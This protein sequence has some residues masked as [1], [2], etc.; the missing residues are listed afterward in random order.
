VRGFGF[1]CYPNHTAH[2]C[3]MPEAGTLGSFIGLTQTKLAIS[4][5]IGTTL[6]LNRKMPYDYFEHW[7]SQCAQQRHKA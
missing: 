6:L 1:A 3:T 7:L 4:S 2:N 5:D